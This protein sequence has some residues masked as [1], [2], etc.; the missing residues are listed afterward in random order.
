MICNVCGETMVGDG[1]TSA[2]HCPNV[3]AY[4]REPDA[5][6]LH[7]GQ[8]VKRVSVM[9]STLTIQELVDMLY[10]VGDVAGMDAP[11]VIRKDET[12]TDFSVTKCMRASTEGNYN[13]LWAAVISLGEQRVARYVAKYVD[14]KD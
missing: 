5:S 4:D 2:M 3:D 10:A 13:Y 11:V 9:P 1:Y 8:E 6:P 7:C 12:V 14:S